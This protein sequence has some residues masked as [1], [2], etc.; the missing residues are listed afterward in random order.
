MPTG[1]C[2]INCDVCRLNLGGVCS[3][4]GAGTSEQGAMKMAA[5]ERILG[6]P[7]PILACAAMNRVAYC[8]Q[9]CNQFPC[10]NFSAGP[11]PFSKGFL[12]MQQRRRQ[13][14]PPARSPAG[15][16]AGIP[17]EYWNRLAALESAD[18]CERTLAVPHESGGYRLAFLNKE[19]WIDLAERKVKIQHG[20]NWESREDPLL[21]LVALLYLNNASYAALR[22][23]MVTVNELKE[24]HFFVGI[25]SL[26]IQ[27]VL[28]RFGGDPHG[29]RLAA[30]AAGGRPE[31]FAD[32]AYVF[33][34]LPK[35]PVTYLLWLGDEEFKPR[36]TVC[37]D[38][39]I[40]KHFA[41][42]G[43]WALVKRL[44]FELLTGI[45]PYNRF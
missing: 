8:M 36:L 10:D 41:A 45:G 26:D 11:Y 6:R 43:I 25:H 30:E 13:E 32:I 22:N 34:A 31:P 38:R 12:E 40:E 16:L 27:G 15:Q 17:E 4:C 1:A 18:V 21:E 19:L 29:F 20:P 3:S 28:D 14:K 42:D 23:E 5:Q 33:P 35:I 44:S 37:F 24:G 9:G 7:C 2:G 39:S